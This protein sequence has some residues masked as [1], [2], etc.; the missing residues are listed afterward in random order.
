[1]HFESTNLKTARL[2]HSYKT[3]MGYFKKPSIKHR[4]VDSKQNALLNVASLKKVHSLMKFNISI[5][6]SRQCTNK[7][8]FI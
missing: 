3:D 6:K 5:I 8:M 7:C 2:F 1:M 4:S